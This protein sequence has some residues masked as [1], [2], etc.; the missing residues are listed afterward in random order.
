MSDIRN[1][2]IGVGV[3]I[4]RDGKVLLGQRRGSHGASTWGFPG[5]HLEFG[6][7][8]EKCAIRETLEETGLT[9]TNVRFMTVTNDIFTTED[10]HYVTIFVRADCPTGESQITEP[11]KMVVWRWFD[12]DN[13]PSPLFLPV[14]HLRESG[15]RP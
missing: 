9:L 8:P 6:E 14:E 11:D 5:G 13:L 2:R 3:F 1:P 4:L 7:S 10:K 12:W 15:F